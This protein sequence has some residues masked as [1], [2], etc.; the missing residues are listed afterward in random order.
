MK[1][2]ER[3]FSSKKIPEKS[4][5]VLFG[6]LD[7]IER[8]ESR[9][10]MEVLQMQKEMIEETA[11]L[12]AEDEDLIDTLTA[13]SVVAKRLAVKLRNELSTEGERQDGKNE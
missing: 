2:T 13:I 5:N 8:Q 12:D 7:Q 11:C 3:K 6:N 1:R 9:S 4:E 10:E